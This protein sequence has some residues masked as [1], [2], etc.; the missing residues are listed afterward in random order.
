MS[1]PCPQQVL[2]EGAWGTQWEGQLQPAALSTG[3]GGEGQ[4]KRCLRGAANF[5]CCLKP[6]RLSRIPTPGFYFSLFSNHILPQVRATQTSYS[7][8]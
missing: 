2:N 3:A 6:V 5:Q 8:N 4:R 7:D 1:N